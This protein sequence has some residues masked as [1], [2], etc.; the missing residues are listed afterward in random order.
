LHPVPRAICAIFLKA[1]ERWIAL[2]SESKRE[3]ANYRQESGRPTIHGSVR[4]FESAVRPVGTSDRTT[5]CRLG[6]LSR[7]SA[8]DG[9]CTLEPGVS[10]FR[11]ASVLVWPMRLLNKSPK[12]SSISST[13]A[14][15][16]PA[17]ASGQIRS[18]CLST[19]VIKEHARK[20]AGTDGSKTL[21]E[22]D[23]RR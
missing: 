19:A 20:I 13:L 17:S 3:E 12:T 4:N 10:Y 18:R 9:Y 5:L 14:S 16:T 21:P 11:S 2:H 22:A 1:L 15:H 23:Q 7:L 6:R 8:A